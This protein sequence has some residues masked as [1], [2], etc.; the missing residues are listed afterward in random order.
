[1]TVLVMLI[2]LAV[3]VTDAFL[4][5]AAFEQFMGGPDAVATAD[6]LTAQTLPFAQEFG[7]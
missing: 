7:S 4:T 3:T 1:M 2:V 5:R 6:V